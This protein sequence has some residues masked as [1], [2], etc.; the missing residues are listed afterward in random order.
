MIAALD[1]RGKYQAP[2]QRPSP[3]SLWRI[4]RYHHAVAGSTPAGGLP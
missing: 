4:P 2:R 3:A 1:R